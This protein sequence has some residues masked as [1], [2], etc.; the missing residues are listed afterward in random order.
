MIDFNIDNYLRI[1]PTDVIL[2]L[3]STA[4]IILFAKH[5]F[6]DKLLAFIQKRQDLIQENIDSSERLKQEAL[7]EKA[8]YEQKM[9]D[10]GK[11]AHAV[12]EEAKAQAGEEKAAILESARNQADRIR[13]SAQEDIVREKRKAEKEMANAISSVALSAAEALVKKEVDDE[14]RAVF[15]ADFIR[16]AGEDERWQTR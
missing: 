15:V 7:Q 9:K 2:V 3:I 10:A 5:F 13:Q 14:E 11:E 8:V 4:L 6:W 16:K 1:S 12:I